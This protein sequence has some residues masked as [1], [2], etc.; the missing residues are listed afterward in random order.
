MEERSDMAISFFKYR[1]KLSLGKKMHERYLL[2]L[3]VHIEISYI[4][5]LY[6]WGGN[7]FIEI[8]L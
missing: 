7:F 4:Y 6:F 1:H 2:N 3:N 5:I 8:D